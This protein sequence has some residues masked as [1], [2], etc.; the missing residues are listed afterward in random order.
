MS[1]NNTYFD[2]KNYLDIQGLSN[3]KQKNSVNN[4]GAK[5]EVAQQFEAMLVQMLVKSMRDANKTLTQEEGNEQTELYQDLFDKQAALIAGH[6]GLGLSKEIEAYLARVTPTDHEGRLDTQTQNP[7]LENNMSAAKQTSDA[8]SSISSEQIQQQ[9]NVDSN[10]IH[11]DNELTFIKNIWEHA[12][13]AAVGLGVDPKVLVAQAALETGWGKRIIAK[14]DTSSHNVFN[15]KTGSNWDKDTALVDTLESRDGVFVKERAAFRVYES[16]ADSFSDYVRL[17]KENPRYRDALN[18]AGS[19]KQYLS[20]LQK[21]EYATDPQYAD[22]VLQIYQSERLQN[23]I[24][25]V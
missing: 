15:I 21:G 13:N 25:Q 3:L 20:Y 2:G 17:I 18:H 1:I 14:A 6:Q 4:E 24:E 10:P 23:L 19:P 22:K 12:K 16:F 11:F 7:V 8:T 5:R 9:L